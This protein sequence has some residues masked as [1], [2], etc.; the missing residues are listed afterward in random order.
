MF[1]FACTKKKI[2]LFA[3]DE[4]EYSIERGLY[5]PLSKLPFPVV[6]D[7]D[8]LISK[9]RSEKNY[10]ETDFLK[11][12]CPYENENSTK[13]IVDFIFFNKTDTL[14]LFKTQDNKKPN[15]LIYGGNLDTNGITKSLLNLLAS[16]DSTKNNY[17]ICYYQNI[18]NKQ[19]NEILNNLPPNIN[20]Y[21]LGSE[22]PETAFE[23]KQKQ[24]FSKNRL[25]V[26]SYV[27]RTKQ[28]LKND[29]TRLFTGIRIDAF[30][31]FSG[32]GSESLTEFSFL[33]CKKAVYVHSNMLMEQKTRQNCRTDVLKYC[34]RNYDAVCA[35]T[36]DLFDS[37]KKIAG[38]KVN[39]Y[40]CPNIIDSKSV[41]LKSEEEI[42]LDS[43]T[44]LSVPEN[45]FFAALNSGKKKFINIGRFS[46][47]KGQIRLI[48]AF[49]KIHSRNPETLLFIIGGYT[50]RGYKTLIE[51]KI[52]ELNLSD[53]V[54]LVEKVS[55]PYAILKKCDYFV[56]SSFYEGFGI[57]VAEADILKKPVIS[58]DVCGIH[59]FMKSHNGFLVSNSED[60]LYYGME[61][62]LEN[63]VAVMNVDFA[64]YDK[65]AVS[66]VEK[67]IDGL[68]KS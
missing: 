37:I 59:G 39:L 35:V 11:T 66:C 1:D 29:I 8:S 51:N 56:F 38:N 25:G 45:D 49:S 63:E 4:T 28:S 33:P 13:N 47:E 46:K 58:T 54:I 2:V 43:Y 42:R 32:Y 60:G 20:F 17:Y 9:I 67:V 31:H 26:K 44:S 34:Y 30:I 7:A 62:L 50:Y 40:E 19:A 55:N 27:S 23:Y 14:S 52:K 41:L 53:S 48:N 15:I 10:D 5:L 36:K 21:P 6:H 22:K 57:V 64:S 18:I 24:K 61:K 12:Y 3:F 16:V 65:N 68:L